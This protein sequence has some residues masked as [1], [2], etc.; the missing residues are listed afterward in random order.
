MRSHGLML[1][2]RGRVCPNG[3][4]LQCRPQVSIQI[5]PAEIKKMQ[6]VNVNLKDYFE[7]FFLKNLDEPSIMPKVDYECKK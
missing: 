2:E 5:F 4:I 6:M 1:A 3:H 7:K